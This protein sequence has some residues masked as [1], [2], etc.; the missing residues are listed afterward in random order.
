MKIEVIRER[1]VEAIQKAEKVTSKNTTL[2]VLKCVLLEARASS[3]FVRSTNL[4]IGLEIHIPAKVHTEG[5]VAVPGS[6]IASYL[7]QISGEKSVNLEHV[8]GSLKVT[9]SKNST[10]IKTMSPEE[11]PSIPKVDK[12]TS[13]TFK[14][15]SRDLVSGLKA[16]WYSSATST[17]KPELSSVRVYPLDNNLVFVATD[18]FRLAEKRIQ[19]K[20]LPDFVHILIPVKNSAE[21]IRIFDGLDEE[22]EVFIDENQIAVVSESIYLVSRTIEGNFPDYKAIIPKEFATDVVL[23]KQDFLNALKISTIF[24]DAFFHIK[25][26]I[27]V[28]EAKLKIATK[29]ND[30]GES[31]T[32]VQATLSGQ[33]MDINFNYRY[34]NDAMVSLSSDSLNFAFSGANRP[35][36]IKPVGDASFMYLVMPM[37]R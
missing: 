33:D 31:S 8:D 10:V 13:K 19:V 23:L 25:F 6:V 24:S 17:I 5:I 2:P 15:D 27:Q 14:I 29:N 18:G 9:T 4:D 35:L 7:N 37:N 36:V 30:I 32:D 26:I 22:V 11:Y 28:K 3:L 21:V 34:I 20:N 1:L 16:V 12:D